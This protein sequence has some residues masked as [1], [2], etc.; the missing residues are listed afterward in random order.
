MW[1]SKIKLKILL[2]VRGW[3]KVSW[4]ISVG[5]Q[6]RTCDVVSRRDRVLHTEFILQKL[7]TLLFTCQGYRKDHVNSDE[8]TCQGF[9]KISIFSCI[10]ADH[11]SRSSSE[12]RN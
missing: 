7:I 10:R 12:I 4:R 1:T 5:N 8:I 2:L 6:F 11:V 3:V 9:M